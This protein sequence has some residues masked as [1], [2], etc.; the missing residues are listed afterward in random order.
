MNAADRKILDMLPGRP[1]QVTFTCD[2]PS[3]TCGFQ[4]WIGRV[5]SFYCGLSNCTA[6]RDVQ[7][8][9]TNTTEYKCEQV[10]CACIPGRMLCGE[11]GSVGEPTISTMSDFLL[12][13]D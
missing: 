10:E 7:Y 2:I 9:G 8:G 1:P 4:F 12:D 3:E 13:K 6:S 11:N 5:E